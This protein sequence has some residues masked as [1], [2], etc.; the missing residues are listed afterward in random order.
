MLDI[1][2]LA[3]ESHTWFR[4][5]CRWPRA[6]MPP[7][8]VSFCA[9]CL[10]VRECT[11]TSVAQNRNT[12]YA[13]VESRF[14]CLQFQPCL[15]SFACKQCFTLAPA[16]LGDWGMK[17]PCGSSLC[18]LPFILTACKWCHACYGSNYIHTQTGH[19]LHQAP[20]MFKN[21]FYI[22]RLK[23]DLEQSFL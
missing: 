7:P 10:W 18:F 17:L 16:S 15:I 9:V 22:Y 6:E 21:P 1:S 13:S 2:K 11:S 5:P 4:V 8:H 3:T 14:V 19:P 23:L 20:F 12:A